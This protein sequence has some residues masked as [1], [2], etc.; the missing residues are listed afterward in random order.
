MKALIL[1][2]GYG[3]RL[4]PLSENK[5]KALLPIG[6]RPMVEHIIEKI[7]EIPGLNEICMVVNQ[8]F[9]GAF[10]DWSRVL[11]TDKKIRVFNDGSTGDENKLG[12]IGDIRFAIQKG[13]IT[14]DLFVVA[15]DNLFD[16]S[17]H[18]FVEFFRE[19]G[20]AV[21]LYRVEPI[22]LVKRYSV[23]EMDENHRILSF[24]E[25]PEHPQTNT[26]AICMYLFPKE[27]LDLVFK[28][29]EQGNNPDAPGYYIKWLVENESVYGFTFSG[30]WFD[31]GDIKCYE[32]A[33]KAFTKEGG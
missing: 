27:K 32:E 18:P 26:I 13:E 25:K 5:A 21:G 33:D 20:T 7:E 2:A 6:G 23:V 29:L 11:E 17:L 8:K 22:E 12:A 16:F 1:A 19:K 30:R 9:H 28:Y 3:T 24:E 14:D 31:I 4:Y 10:E 15:G